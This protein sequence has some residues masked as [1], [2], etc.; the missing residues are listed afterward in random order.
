M[1]RARQLACAL[2]VTVVLAGGAC[3]DDGA[4]PF[5][6]EADV[7]GTWVRDEPFNELTLSSYWVPVRDTLVLRPDRSGRWSVTVVSAGAP[8]PVRLEQH[9]QFEPS[10][11]R[12][13]LWAI[14]EPCDACRLVD[15]R[16]APANW[17]AVRKS[18]DL[19]ELRMLLGPSL[20]GPDVAWLPGED[21]YRYRRTAAP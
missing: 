14:P 13:R 9:V 11:L 4:S 20:E 6:P 21:V 16:L 5:A 17:I 7:A 2:A 18:E 8:M 15:P 1:T 3:A 10:G 12:L 19:L